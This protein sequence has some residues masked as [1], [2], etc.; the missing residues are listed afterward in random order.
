VKKRE[1]YPLVRSL[2]LQSGAL[3]IRTVRSDP[4]HQIKYRFKIKKNLTNEKAARVELKKLPASISRSLSRVALVV[5]PLTLHLI[6]ISCEIK[7]QY[8]S[9]MEVDQLAEAASEENS[10]SILK[11][12]P[13]AARSQLILE[14]H[15]LMYHHARIRKGIK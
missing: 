3:Y 2:S 15:F 13:A 4:T 9:V 5:V 10:I 11:A 14:H 7:N 12:K 6:F 1:P 8:L